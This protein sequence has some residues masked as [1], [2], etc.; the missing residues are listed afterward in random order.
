MRIIRTCLD[1]NDKIRFKI[2]VEIGH[3]AQ[4]F[5]MSVSR[6]KLELEQF[7]YQFQALE[8]FNKHAKLLFFSRIRL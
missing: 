7:W 3:F 5:E 2:N 8:N 1:N 4:N 6:K